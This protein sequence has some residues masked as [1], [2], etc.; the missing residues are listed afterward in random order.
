MTLMSVATGLGQSVT[1]LRVN[2]AVT[3]ATHDGTSWDTAYPSLQE[4]ITA[5][6]PTASQRVEIWVAKGTYKPTDDSDR[7]KAFTL[8]SYL[9]IRGAFSGTETTSNGR[10][11]PWG[12]PTVLSGDIG[13]AMIGAITDTNE[14]PLD[15]ASTEDAGWNDNSHNVLV[16][17]GVAGVILDSLTITGASAT[18]SDVAGT[19]I[20]GYESYSANPSVVG[21]QMAVKPSSKVV[22]G[23]LYLTEGAAWTVTNYSLSMQY[24][25][26]AR[27]RARAFGGGLGIYDASAYL[28]GCSFENN[29]SDRSGGAV[30]GL[31]QQSGFVKCTF[32]DNTSQNGGGAVSL[33]GLPSPRSSVRGSNATADAVFNGIESSAMAVSGAVKYTAENAQDIKNRVSQTITDYALSKVSLDLSPR[34]SNNSEGVFSELASRIP[35]NPVSKDDVKVALKVFKKAREVREK[36][37]E[38]KKLPNFSMRATPTNVYA[39]IKLSVQVADLLVEVLNHYG[40]V[41]QNNP[42]YQNWRTFSVNFNKYGTPEGLIQSAIDAKLDSIDMVTPKIVAVKLNQL[43]NYYTLAGRSG[44]ASCEFSGNHTKTFGGAIEVIFNNLLVEN[45]TFTDNR[46]EVAGAAISSSVYNLPQVVSSV[47]SNNFSDLGTS[48]IA[49]S[50]GSIMRVSNCTIINNKSFGPDGTALSATMGADMR[51]FNSILWNNANETVTTGADVLVTSPDTMDPDTLSKY[52]ALT[53]GQ[54]ANWVGIMDIRNSIIQSLATI[55]LGRDHLTVRLSGQNISQAEI[56]AALAS[57]NEADARGELEGVGAVNAG[58]GVRPKLRDPAYK[59]SAQDPVLLST[60]L[61]KPSWTSPVLDAGDD[62]WST[63]RLVEHAVP[64]VNLM[65]VSGAKRIQNTRVDIGAFEV[66]PGVPDTAPLASQALGEQA[67]TGPLATGVGAGSVPSIGTTTPP[68]TTVYFVKPGASDSANGLTWGTATSLKTALGKVGTSIEIWVATGTYKP[69]SDNTRT[70]SFAMKNGVRIFGGFTGSETQ[71]SA[72]NWKQNPTVIS[73]DIGVANVATDNSKNLF[74]NVGVNNTALLDGFILQD[75]YSSDSDGGAILNTL[76]SAPLI[77]NCIFKNN[78]AVNGGAIHSS[79]TDDAGSILVNC[80]FSDNSAAAAG[81]AVYY[82]QALLGNN[83]VFSGNSAVAGGGAITVS[84]GK[85]LQYCTIQNGLFYGNSSTAQAGGAIFTHGLY[86]NVVNSTF[87]GNTAAIHSDEKSGGGAIHHSYA[88]DAGMASVVIYNSIFYKNA[89]TNSGTGSIDTVEKQQIQT[90]DALLLSHSMVQGLKSYTG[91]EL[92]DNLAGDPQFVLEGSDFRLLPWSLAI[93]AGDRSAN[94]YTSSVTTDLNGGKRTING[95]TDLGAYES[96]ATPPHPVRS[97]TQTSNGTSYTLSAA[98]N[99]VVGE[100]IRWYVDR[101]D[102][103]GFVPLIESGENAG[104]YTS[105]LVV[106][107]PPTGFTYRLQIV[108]NGVVFTSPSTKLEPTADSI[109]KYAYVKPV[110]TGDG[111]GSSWADAT[112]DLQ[113][114]LG[115]EGRRVFVAAGTYKPTSGTNRDASFSMAKGVK[116]YGGMLGRE[117]SVDPDR[118]WRNRRTTISGEIGGAGATDNS[119]NLFKNSNLGNSGVLDGLYFKDAYSDGEGGAIQNIDSGLTIQNCVFDSN[120]ARNGGAISST[121]LPAWTR[122]I[123]C[124]FLNN[125][126]E[127]N[128]GALDLA[129]SWSGSSLIFKNN[130]ALKGGAIHSLGNAEGDGGELQNSL[131]ALNSATGGPGGAVFMSG[132]R[133]GVMNSTFYGNVST[134]SSTNQAS[135]GGI[136]LDLPVTDSASLSVLNSIFYKNVARNHGTGGRATLEKQQIFQTAN[137]YA[138]NNSLI[139]GPQTFGGVGNFEG[140]PGFVNPEGWDFHVTSD[141]LTIDAGSTNGLSSLLQTTDL[142]GFGRVENGI[143]DLGPYEHAPVEPS[144]LKKVAIT[145][146]GLENYILSAEVIPVVASVTQGPDTGAPVP[147]GTPIDRPVP[148]DQPDIT[149]IVETK[150]KTVAVTKVTTKVVD[151][152]TFQWQVDRGDGKGFV[153]LGDR[154]PDNQY[155]PVHYLGLDTPSLTILT[156]PSGYLFRLKNVRAMTTTVVTTTV[157]TTATIVTTTNRNIE[158][159]DAHPIISYYDTYEV[160]HSESDTDVV[161]ETI[162]ATETFYSPVIRHN[163]TEISKGSYVYVRPKATGDGSGSGWANATSDLQAAMTHPNAQ[164]W[165]QKGTYYPT[166][167][168]DRNVSFS[169]PTYG[170]KVY[171]GFKGTETLRDA[172]NH[173]LNVTRISGNIGSPS[174][175]HDNSRHL[176]KNTGTARSTTLDGF[177]LEDAYSD[178][179]DGGAIFN[180]SARPTLQNCIFQNNYAR[181]G[182]AVFST[183]NP[184]SGFGSDL[185][186]CRFIDNTAELTGGAISYNSSLSA[187]NVVFQGNKAGA[188]GAIVFNGNLTGEAFTLKNGLFFNNRSLNGNGGAIFSKGLGLNIANST[189]Y[190]NQA[191]LNSAS[192]LGGGAIYQDHRL[193][194][195]STISVYN[196]IFYGNKAVNP[197]TGGL[198]SLE[199]QQIE[200]RDNGGANAVHSLIQGL[201]RYANIASFANFDEDP[202]FVNKAAGDFHLSNVS[203]AINSGIAS[204]GGGP[205]LADMDLDGKAR[206]LNTVDLGPYEFTGSGALGRV[207]SSS[208]FSSGVVRFYKDTNITTEAGDVLQWYVDRGDG[209]GFVLLAAS[210]V[211][212]GV[213]TTRLSIIGAPLSDNGFLFRLQVKRGGANFTT[214]ATRLTLPLPR[215]Y[216]DAARAGMAADGAGW[217]TAYG[218]LSQ[219][220]KASGPGSSVWVAGGNYYPTG[221]SNRDIAFQIPAGVKIYGGF[222]S[223]TARLEDR[224]ATQYPTILSGRINGATAATDRYQYSRHVVMNDAG[225][226]ATA[227]LDGFILQDSYSSLLVNNGA[228]PTIRNCVF[229]NNDSSRA[230]DGEG[231]AVANFNGANPLIAECRF[232][233]NTGLYAGALYIS[234]AGATVE[235]SVFSQNTALAGGAITVLNGTLNMVHSTVVDNKSSGTRGAALYAVSSTVT[236]G[237]SI[238]WN[239]KATQ[240]GASVYEQAVQDYGSSI[241]FNYSCV[242]GGTGLPETNVSSTPLFDP[243]QPLDPYRLASYSPLVNAGSASYTVSSSKDQVGSPRVFQLLPDMGAYE[244]QTNAPVSKVKITSLPKSLTSYETGVDVDFTVTW[245]AGSTL[246]PNWKVVDANN[247]LLA[248]SRYSSI[249]FAPNTLTLRIKNISLADS[250]TQISFTDIAQGLYYTP[251]AILTVKIPRIIRVNPAATGIAN[252]GSSWKDAYKDLAIAMDEAET[253]DEIWVVGGTYTP[254]GA[255]S[256][257]NLNSFNLKPTVK[258]YGGFAGTETQRSDRDYLARPT[259]L[260]PFGSHP[261]VNSDSSDPDFALSSV[262]DGFVVENGTGPIAIYN[263]GA[264]GTFR[265]CTFRNNAGYIGNFKSQ[266]LYD[267]CEF[268]GNTGILHFISE[269]P[270]TFSNCKINSNTTTQDLINSYNASVVTLSDTV[271]SNNT[272]AGAFF[273]NSGGNEGLST[274]N[275][276]R[277]AFRSNSTGGAVIANNGKSVIENSLFARNIASAD[278]STIQS[279][280]TISII[281]STIADN[282]GGSFGGGLATYSSSVST[283]NGCIFWGNRGTRASSTTEAQQVG[284]GSGTLTVQ[285]SIVEGLTKYNVGGSLNQP[286]YP[287]FVDSHAGDYHLTIN[288]PALEAVQTVPVTTALDLDRKPRPVSYVDIGAYQFQFARDANKVMRLSS[289][290]SSTTTAEFSGTS[291]TVAGQSAGYQWQYLAADGVTWVN[292]TNNGSFT[293][294]TSVNGDSSSL[295]ILTPSVALDGTHFRVIITRPGGISYTSGDLVLTVKAPRILYVNGNVNTSGNGTSWATAFKTV[296]EALAVTDD[297]SEIW[298]QAGSHTLPNSTFLAWYAHLYGGF[299]GNETERSQR[300]W[301]ANEVTLSTVNGGQIFNTYDHVT[302]KAGGHSVLD[303]FILTGTSGTASALLLYNSNA[304]VANCTFTGNTTA[305]NSSGLSNPVITNCLFES[306]SARAMYLEVLSASVSGCSFRNNTNLSYNGAVVYISKGNVTMKDCTFSGNQTTGATVNLYGD[307]NPDISSNLAAGTATYLKMSRCR[308]VGNAAYSM[309]LGQMS[310]LNLDNSLI[311]RNALTATAFNGY[312]NCVFNLT[313]VTLVE[314]TGTFQCVGIQLQGGRWSLKNSIIWGNRTSWAY[315]GL[316]NPGSPSIMEESQIKLSNTDPSVT[317]SIV[318]GAYYIRQGANPNANSAYEPLFVDRAAQNYQLSAASPA[319]NKG[320]ATGIPADT[321]DLNARPRAYASTLPDMGAYELQ[322]AAGTPVTFT[323]NL[324][325]RKIVVELNTQYSVQVP[326]GVDVQWQ[327]S[328]GGAFVNIGSGNTLNLNQLTLGMSGNKYRFLLSGAFSFTSDASVLTVIPKPIVYVNASATGTRDGKSWANAFVSPSDAINGDYIADP[329]AAGP[330]EIWI[331][332]GTYEIAD[333]PSIKPGAEIYGGF[334]GNE[335]TRGERNPQSHPAILR[336]SGGGSRVNSLYD[337]SNPNKLQVVIDGLTFGGVGSGIEMRNS[338]TIIRNC[339]FTSSGDYGITNYASMVIEDCT[340]NKPDTRAV[341][342]AF[343]STTTI[344]RCAITGGVE[345]NSWDPYVTNLT[346]E[347]SVFQNTSYKNCVSAGG[348]S[349]EITRCR[350][351]NNTST[352]AIYATRGSMKIRETLIANNSGVGI[353]SA[354]YTLLTNVTIAR[355][356]GYGIRQ[357]A[358]ESFVGLFNSIVAENAAPQILNNGTIGQTFGNSLVQN[359]DLTGHDASVLKWEPLFTNSAA[360][361]FTLSARSPAVDSGDASKVIEGEVDLAGNPR[362]RSSAPDMGAFESSHVG[363]P[364]R[365]GGMPVSAS[366]VR[367]IDGS[368]SLSGD[369][370]YTYTWQYFNGSEWIT[371]TDS[372]TGPGGLVFKITKTGDTSTLK[373]PGAPLGANG[374]QIR[375]SID[376]KGVTSDPLTLTVTE[377]EIIYVDGSVAASGDGRTW[378]TAYKTLSEVTANPSSPFDPNYAKRIVPARR[379]IHIAAGTYNAPAAGYRF[380]QRAELYG[381]F[382]VGGAAF[383][384]RDPLANPVILSGAPVDPGSGGR[385]NVVLDIVGSAGSPVGGDTVFDGFTVDGGQ[386]GIRVTDA[387]P[388]LRNLTVSNNTN[389]GLSATTAGGRVENCR[390]IGNSS[391]NSGGGAYLNKGTLIFSGCQFRGNSAP[392]GGAIFLSNNSVRFESCVISGNKALNDGGGIYVSSGS[393]TLVNCTVAG[394][395]ATNGAGGYVYSGGDLNVLNSIVW[396]NRSSSGNLLAQQLTTHIFGG[397]Y[398]LEYSNVE[399]LAAS[400]SNFSVDPLFLSVTNAAGAPTQEGDLHVYEGSPLVDKGADAHIPGALVDAD[401]APRFV[402]GVDI[403][404]YEIQGSASDPLVITQQPADLVIAGQGSNEFHAALSGTNYNYQW[405][406]STNGVTFTSVLDGT[407]FAGAQTATLRLI[408]RNP[409]LHGS[410]FRLRI[411]GVSGGRIFSRAA[412]LAVYPTRYYVNSAAADD[413]G[414][415]I[416]WETAF[417]TLGGALAKAHAHPTDGVQI[418]VVGGAY[419][420]STTDPAVSFPLKSKVSIYGGFAGNETLLSERN[421]VTRPTILKGI[422]GTTA[423]FSNS[424]A[425]ALT[426]MRIEGFAFSDAA[427]GIAAKN[428]GLAVENCSFTGLGTGINGDLGTLSVKKCQFTGLAQ[429][430]IY[431]TSGALSVVE[432][433]FT[434][435]HQGL[436]Q[437]YGSLSLIRSEFRG[438]GAVE[439]TGG[440]LKTYVVPAAIENCLFSGNYARN[441]GGTYFQG[442]NNVVLRNC[443]I[444][445]NYGVAGTGGVGFER[446]ENTGR[447]EMYNSVVWNNTTSGIAQWANYYGTHFTTN[448]HIEYPGLDPLFVAPIP[449]ALGGTT[450]GDYRF[451][452]QSPLINMGS[453]ADAGSSTTDL[454]SAPR[455]FE[456]KV[457]VGAYEYQDIPLRLTSQPVDARAG[458]GIPVSFSVSSNLAHAIYQWQVSLDGGGTWNNVVESSSESNSTTPTLGVLASPTYNGR[459]YRAY[460]TATA[461]SGSLYS[462]SATYFFDYAVAQ[463]PTGFRDATLTGRTSAISFKIQGGALPASITDG[464]VR[465]SGMQTGRLSLADGSISGLTI[466]GDTVT[467]QTA[468]PFKPGELV[469]V[470]IGGGV[471]RSDSYSVYPSV[472]RFTAGNKAS[473]SGL[474]PVATAITG[475]PSTATTLAC[476][477]LNGDGFVDLVIGSSN[478]A[479]VWTN[480]G[481]AAFTAKNQTLGTGTVSQIL[482]GSL[483]MT[484]SAGSVNKLD[485]VLL[486]S[487]GDVEI[488][489]NEGDGTFSKTKTI[490]GMAATSLGMGDL[491]ADGAPDLFVAT[492]GADQVWLN[493][494]VGYFSDSG[495]RLGTGAG[496][497]VTLA[498]FNIDDRLDVC[499]ANGSGNMEICTNDGTGNFS[500]AVLANSNYSTPADRVIASDYDKNGRTEIFAIYNSGLKVYRYSTTFHSYLDFF[501]PSGLWT[502]D[503]SSVI[504]GDVDGSGRPDLVYSSP[505]NGPLTMRYARSYDYYFLQSLSR[506]EYDQ[507]TTQPAHSFAKAG[508]LADLNGDGMMDSVFISASGVPT[509]SLYAAEPAAPTNLAATAISDTRIALAW[510]DNDAT[511]TSYSVERSPNGNNGWTV[512][513]ASLPANSTSYVDAARNAS[514][515]YYYR[516]RCSVAGIIPSQYSNRADTATPSA[517]GANAD[518]IAVLEGGNATTL[519][520]GATSV[521]AND[522]SPDA[523]TLV[524][525]VV[526]A[527]AHGNLTL[528]ADGTFSYTPTGGYSGTDSFVYRVTNQVTGSNAAVT[529]AIVVTRLNE[530]PTGLTLTPVVGTHYTGQS[531]GMAV[532]TLA[533]TDPD[534]EDTGHFTFSLV[535]GDGSSDNGDFML[536]GATLKTATEIDA[537]F[538]LTRSVRVRV[539]DVPGLFYE[540]SFTVTFNQ[541]PTAVPASFLTDEDTPLAVQLPGEGGA[542]SLSYNIVNPP[543]HGSLAAIGNGAY[544]YTPEANFNGSDSFTY[545]VIDANLSSAPATVTMTVTPVDDAPTLDTINPVE[546]RENTPVS[547]TLVGHDVE[548]AAMTYQLVG[549]PTLGTVQFDDARVTYT[550]NSNVLGV[551]TLTFTVTAGGLTSAPLPVVVTIGSEAVALTVYRGLYENS[552]FPTAESGDWSGALFGIISPPAHGSVTLDG[553]LLR[554]THNNDAAT[555]DSFTYTLTNSTGGVRTISV[556]VAIKDHNLVVSSNADSGPNTLREALATAERF[557]EVK[558]TGTNASTNW[559][560]RIAIAPESNWPYETRIKPITSFDP[561]R[562]APFDYTTPNDYSSFYRVLGNVTIDASDSPGFKL[563]ADQNYLN[564]IRFFVVPEGSSLTLKNIEIVNGWARG[565][566]MRNAKGGVV[567]NYGTLTAENVIFKTSN[568]TEGAAIYNDRGTVSLTGCD[569]IDSTK[570]AVD[571]VLTS[572]VASRNGSFALN[573]VTFSGTDN[574][575][576]VDVHVIGNGALATVNVAASTIRSFQL[577]TSN[578]GTLSI[579]GLPQASDDNVTRTFGQTL[580]LTIDSLL[581]NDPSANA[582]NVTVEAVS[583]KGGTITRTGNNLLYTAP[584]GLTGNDT[585]HY[586]VTIGGLTST[587]TVT[588]VTTADPVPRGSNDSA[589][590][591]RG[592]YESIDVLANDTVATGAPL[593]ISAV[594]SP[595]HGTA[596]ISGTRILYTH[597]GDAATSD[598]FT[599]SVSTSTHTTAN[600]TVNVTIK[601][602]TIVANSNADSGA[603]T[604]RAALEIVNRFASLDNAPVWTVQIVTTNNQTWKPTTNQNQSAFLIKGKVIIDATALT[605]FKL[606]TNAGIRCFT[607]AEQGSLTLK[608][609]T[610]LGSNSVGSTGT[611]YGGAVLN[612]GTLIAN[613]VIFQNHAAHHGAAIFNDGGSVS[614]TGCSFT[615]NKIVSK[616]VADIGG[617]IASRNGTLNITRITFTNSTASP[618]LYVYGDGNGKT[619]TAILDVAPVYSYRFTTFNN[620]SL[621]TPGLALAHNDSLERLIGISFEIPIST[622][623]ANDT[624]IAGA[625]LSIPSNS[626]KG[627]PIQRNGDKISYQVEAWQKEDDTFTYTFTT[628]GGYVTTATVSIKAKAVSDIMVTDENGSETNDGDT[629]NFGAL[630]A[631]N[632]NIQKF[633]NISNGGDAD[634]TGLS[635]TVD[636]ANPGDFEVVGPFSNTVPANVFTSTSFVVIFTP[637]AKG[638]RTATLHIASND[639]DESP[640]DIVLKG[641]INNSPTFDG[642]YV[643]VP[644]NTSVSVPIAK[645]VAKASDEDGD[646]LTFTIPQRTQSRGTLTRNGT[647][648]NYTPPKDLW[649]EDSFQI[650][651][652]DPSGATV[653]GTVILNVTGVDDSPL[654]GNLNPPKLTIAGGDIKLSFQGIPNRAY[655]IERSVNLGAWEKIVTLTANNLG[656]IEF[657]DANPP[658]GSGFYRIKKH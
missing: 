489:K 199:I 491:N 385:A 561:P 148:D 441:G 589:I 254:P 112:S 222:N 224:N 623:L 325:D 276:H 109:A 145:S 633:F 510:T 499:T 167:G 86:L 427:T 365:T 169:M 12:N 204:F 567:L 428:A 281:A 211:Y 46:A 583:G 444:A 601:D 266:V 294:V 215:I 152:D 202:E 324:E 157:T 456:D 597:N 41:D 577:G 59:N 466:V 476:G 572:I 381:G 504:V 551:E 560:I 375:V 426:D 292:V 358:S 301:V 309:V 111:D 33:K 642:Y 582:A 221:G 55:P 278:F 277:C 378:A 607:V 518:S 10:L 123:N 238:F 480:N 348:T 473:S 4:A 247:Q 229:R 415:G 611:F 240:R 470:S 646:N 390:F 640:F 108:R 150:E 226:D 598:S 534:P 129:G 537:A 316:I 356:G 285:K 498:D 361:D 67:Y 16:G 62:R 314:N 461:G 60:P 478:G 538:G 26:F 2:Q 289:F 42:H 488:W 354:G 291:F 418:W 449:G 74:V 516:V 377:P 630:D 609:L 293:I 605:G 414:H 649:G 319:V 413:S 178:N 421:P 455:I 656:K 104:V 519:V 75:A 186:N 419:Q 184:A 52:N 203:G 90:P 393:S 471:K 420:P 216:V 422:A 486:K 181:N 166:S 225:Q 430:G 346:I 548:G 508:E 282:Y 36:V 446:A 604:L 590:V 217:N 462:N 237:N 353:N 21:A 424:G 493:D 638:L 557:R 139:E 280:G 244:L 296:Q 270:V 279:S 29:V 587:A 103:A 443:T 267:N 323:S 251:P 407:D 338:P 179:E 613:T 555:S 151:S 389:S 400:G 134:I 153:A 457:D 554:Y 18:D 248:Q 383:D 227:V 48:A 130:T 501:T 464:N 608:K 445:G 171:G 233:G 465:V 606:T 195:V 450:A 131:F 101:G 193:S 412:S 98:Y 259:I 469:E 28:F 654:A 261:V 85:A 652:R 610:I 453:N 243:S 11:N 459:V 160:I 57:R 228:S 32:T 49:A 322:G 118:D 83:L 146:T 235:N 402:R 541:V 362:I 596:V 313:N 531:A 342:G 411:S 38:I 429:Y 82:S 384:S 331:A 559:N 632:I 288:S 214:T 364:L 376:G 578:G 343:G 502:G 76:N 155:L 340:F 380:D 558:L 615:T 416:T 93:D 182:A 521:L 627:I 454:I 438:N 117:T 505:S 305:I 175:A 603:G 274:V 58:W 641:W 404:A 594:G 585:F 257:Y 137:E 495:Q 242:E 467:M 198:A 490:A 304:V 143:I 197:G 135:G 210:G 401:N 573:D 201:D 94:F 574:A 8:K 549:T 84:A 73:G 479:T 161:T 246:D 372:M 315:T 51:V 34:A 584:A 136:Y 263:S 194:G 398:R 283:V 149:K 35:G 410:L 245:P 370:A 568:A 395:S 336:K 629:C 655:D 299:A 97:V 65:D 232:I 66:N 255:V 515:R 614:L 621:A 5:A 44:F 417:K 581:S 125:T 451:L 78:H 290:P 565:S 477:D 25:K 258:L 345:T 593:S 273:R 409:D 579:T 379:I 106:A 234:G 637:S 503:T 335:T 54:Q 119:R 517:I 546:T 188:G 403:G 159:T 147:V 496:K 355:N 506:I 507:V 1:I 231:S 553:S 183:G 595:A 249:Q 644:Y 284:D 185:I 645:I 295:N 192:T 312:T 514:T 639:P 647:T 447:L 3:G 156:P 187:L 306:N 107:S 269:S 53:E 435:N 350:L 636:G 230:S 658:P 79:G 569:F 333:N 359:K 326:A 592:L 113:S 218:D 552:A 162:P 513:A 494:G 190:G 302:R 308:M 431:A 332:Q 39:I 317:N 64:L 575:P 72:R 396:A 448:T 223:A 481:T 189:F 13:T 173:V 320:T 327:V 337:A 539:T 170:V 399:G 425:T 219:A 15:L 540:K 105:T 24:C 580:A 141:S 566:Y 391:T 635:I 61:G 440:A 89:A 205:L 271:A 334:A 631:Y 132:L 310:L 360:G 30:W 116:I 154:D 121:G 433:T 547:F 602:R 527:P 14:V 220:L 70:T 96:L 351:I 374:L 37:M 241:T 511:E 88:V 545:R 208:D 102:G 643:N 20:D 634:L 366:V 368:F 533:A 482:M 307:Q 650:T 439:V 31:N 174:D 474:F 100:T 128:G 599:Y 69:T 386:T 321:L 339:T 91:S 651:F 212:S 437:L 484:G 87:Y 600:V 468:V 287:F 164:V 40:L 110:A 7:T 256:Y 81:G 544:I 63:G 140:D 436:V 328:T 253:A 612:Y 19:D 191:T 616:N 373:I 158:F 497:S 532:A 619:A 206:V 127:I 648:I 264:I 17:N 392:S 114:V 624:E 512:I 562:P 45:C 262:L 80:E 9:T 92:D 487:S 653:T 272:I 252:D 485:L 275:V 387:G 163:P 520:S 71:R 126:A 542:N 622:L 298:V 268:T 22:G 303:G 344:R 168:T 209:K 318:E 434:T 300:D 352:D 536:A 492:A 526:T 528:N 509:V 50:L 525:S 311:A 27:N 564:Y 172:R 56:D 77:Q 330:R 530:A 452:P 535:D 115:V 122:L 423:I 556:A 458:V 588:I 408:S 475:A 341:Y 524:A 6:N 570:A 196:S 617:I 47:F 23:G 460:V 144:P 349:V 239:N 165:V 133:L 382:P 657:T 571:A 177:T 99:L 586:T 591:Y 388:R 529:V 363:N 369:A 68:N 500:V 405:E 286:Y 124:E 142:D 347:D 472:Y 483:G 176:F 357:S 120:H 260:R 200:V 180:T 95:V 618:E 620:G 367:G 432:S 250:G 576:D 523:G 329:L 625:T 43:N 394:N 543:G 213:N 626:A 207:T 297:N 371:I 550:P 138:V 406:I 442:G 236:A 628:A 463:S 265:N 563:T 397:A 522:N